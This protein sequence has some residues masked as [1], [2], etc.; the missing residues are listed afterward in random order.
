MQAVVMPQAHPRSVWRYV[1][2]QPSPVQAAARTK[3]ERT[4]QSRRNKPTTRTATMSVKRQR[5]R[6]AATNAHTIECAGGVHDMANSN[7]EISRCSGTIPKQ[8]NS[9]VVIGTTNAR[10]ASKRC[11]SSSVTGTYINSRPRAFCG[12]PRKCQPQHRTLDIMKQEK[13][14]R[15]DT[16]YDQENVRTL[17]SASGISRSCRTRL[18]RR[19]SYPPVR[20]FVLQV[21]EE[22]AA[23]VPEGTGMLRERRSQIPTRE[24]TT[25]TMPTGCPP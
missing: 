4:R 3:P 18:A 21:R 19:R 25:P 16:V 11:G 6:T 5:E 23:V 24:C 1:P 10:S 20:C 22:E 17:A 13:M 9:V 14:P 12:F 2:H 7:E 8:S 15:T